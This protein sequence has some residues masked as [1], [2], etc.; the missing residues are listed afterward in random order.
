MPEGLRKFGFREELEP[1]VQEAWNATRQMSLVQRADRVTSRVPSLTTSGTVAFHAAKIAASNYAPPEPP[2]VTRHMFMPEFIGQKRQIFMLELMIQKCRAEMAKLADEVEAEKKRFSDA[3][4]EISEASDKYKVTTVRVEASVARGRVSSDAAAKRRM[5][6]QKEYSMTRQ[7][8]ALFRAQIAVKRRRLEDYQRY[9][10]FEGTVLPEGVTEKDFYKDPRNLMQELRHIENNTM[11]LVGHLD[12]LGE[13]VEKNCEA[14]DAD[15]A[16]VSHDLAL[17]T[18]RR[19]TLPPMG[20]FSESLTSAT[21]KLGDQIDSELAYLTKLVAHSHV[22]C[23]GSKASQNLPALLMLERIANALDN[24]FLKLDHVD[25]QYAVAKQK[26]KDEQR[27]E[28]RKLDAAERRSIEQK[29]KADAAV[30]RAQLPIKKRTGRPPVRRTLPIT[31][32]RK[33]PERFRAARLE[34]ERIERFLYGPEL[35]E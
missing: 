24:W 9:A 12:R 28:Q 15:I 8:T 4:R 16:A 2:N 22:H 7:R 26:I 23:L 3:E 11:S 1:Q 34:R 21:V 27:L 35:I 31:V 10:V 17:L 19:K 30:E 6:L 33:D 18:E 5:E 14:I 20:E 13:T 29:L 25:S 32:S